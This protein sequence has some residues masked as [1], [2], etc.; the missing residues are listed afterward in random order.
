MTSWASIAKAP[1]AVA[2]APADL[3]ADAGL[4]LLVVDANAIISGLRLE[5]VADRAVTIQE[6]LDEVRD[7]QSR[8][9]L[10]ALPYPL[11]VREPAEE[12][13]RAVTRFA[14][15]TGDVAVLSAT[16]LKL[17]ALAHTLEVAAHGGGHLAAH[18]AQ[19]RVHS[20]AITT[21]AALPGWGS[22]PNPE[23]WREVDEANE[24][25]EA[26]AEAAGAS[27]IAQHVQQLSLDPS[28][29]SAFL[30]EQPQEPAQ[31]PPQQQAQQ[32][33]PQPQPQQAQHAPAPGAPPAPPEAPG[34]ADDD[35]AGDADDGGWEVAAS[36]AAAARR[37][38]RK[39]HK[40]A[41]KQLA[42]EQEWEDHAALVAEQ[43]AQAQPQQQQPGGPPHGGAGAA[44]EPA[45][46]GSGSGDGS[47]EEEEDDEG[48]EEGEEGEGEEATNDDLLAE[49]HQV[50]TADELGGPASAADGAADAG[51]AAGGDGAAGGAPGSPGWQSSVASVTADFAMQNVL[52]Q[53]GLRLLTADGRRVARLSRYALRC[54]ACFAVTREPGRLF[55]P[56][57]G[58]MGL[59]RVEVVVGPGGAEYFGVRKRHVLRGTRYSLPKPR[60]G[61]NSSDPVLREDVFLL[62][63]KA[64]GR[65]GRK[66]KG[67]AAGEDGAAPD[68][69]APE[70]GADTW[71]VATQA[72]LAQHRG[73]AAVLQPAWKNNPNERKLTR[74]NRRG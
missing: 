50:V 60:G 12:S 54:G 35:D 55:C 24:A 43:R 72:E 51:G 15:E 10:A 9:W 58:T 16:D 62:R 25:D 21:A 34:G 29:P 39:E 61:R 68:P 33:P 65:R 46:S 36:S 5:G 22:V 57:C 37:K 19:P 67:P 20:K 14:R 23:D 31:Q 40:R 38:R 26:A 11:V 66:A 18:A 69:F 8:Q 74:S 53:M 45:G 52:L 48:E 2:A 7:K 63:V 73:L 70:F 41:E 71:H 13:L 3:G 49:P 47:A 4:R 64:L 6:V 30:Q 56:K 27:R 17:L 32:P 42:F 1:A 44:G 59:D 28:Q